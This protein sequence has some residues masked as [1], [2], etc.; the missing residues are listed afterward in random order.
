MTEPESRAHGA[1]PGKVIL[2]GEHAVVYGYRAIAAPLASGLGTT[3]E[4]GDG[5]AT[6]NIPRWGQG[7]LTVQPT[8]D[9]QG[10]DAMSFAFA[11]ALRSLKLDVTSQVKV[12]I[13]GQLPLGVGLGSSAAFAVSLIRGL[14]RFHKIELS[15][16]ALLSCAEEVETV[17]HGTP[18]GLDHTVIARSQCLLYHRGQHPTFQ[19]IDVRHAIP[20]VVAWAPR[21]GTTKEIVAGVRARHDSTPQDSRHCFGPWTD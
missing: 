7:G 4:A 9:S 3:V 15:D 14:A 20:V 16:D 13:D 2:F 8:S 18:S 5:G 17:F 10:P 6:L 11:A 12:T 1:A 21:V 19:P